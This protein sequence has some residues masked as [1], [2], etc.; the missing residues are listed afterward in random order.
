M[1]GALSKCTE[2]F[3]YLEWCLDSDY[4]IAILFLRKIADFHSCWGE[5]S[6]FCR[7]GREGNFHG[8]SGRAPFLY[9]PFAVFWVKWKTLG[10]I[11][12]SLFCE[13]LPS[14]NPTF[15]IF[16]LLMG[17]SFLTPEYLFSKLFW[18]HNMVPA[19]KEYQTQ[20]AGYNAAPK[21]T[22]FFCGA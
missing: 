21:L 3:S 2:A 20:K 12:Y 10:S 22:P 16:Q 14:P 17:K 13:V 6:R 19:P 1:W 18:L 15:F 8:H 4:V 9:L 5:S 11:C 7:V